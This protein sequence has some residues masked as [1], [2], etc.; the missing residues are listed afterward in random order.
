[1]AIIGY[2][3]GTSDLFT[4]E[5]RARWLACFLDDGFVLPSRR[6]MEKDMMEWDRHYKKYAGSSSKFYRRSSIISIQTWYH[7]RLCRD[8]GC[9]PRR[10]KGFL[11]D[12][13][14]PYSPA[15]YAGIEFEKKQ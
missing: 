13:F 8:M 6:G 12:L 3:E 4:T 1:M 2:S 11:K 14:V 10:K 9:N 15:D 5:L 7:D